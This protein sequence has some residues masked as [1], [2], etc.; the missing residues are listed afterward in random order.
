MSEAN[1]KKRK[2]NAFEE[3][4]RLVKRSLKRSVVMHVQL[5]V[6]LDVIANGIENHFVK[7]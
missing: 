1:I 4:S 2:D 5:L 7:E 6:L 3:C